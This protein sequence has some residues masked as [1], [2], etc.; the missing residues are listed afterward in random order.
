MSKQLVK[1]FLS[2]SKKERIGIIC[3]VSLILIIITGFYLYPSQPKITN[4][5]NQKINRMID[6]LKEKQEENSDSGHWRNEEDD[7]Q[8]RGKMNYPSAYYAKTERKT[9]AEF[10]EFNPN[11]ATE[12]DWKRLGISGKT[13]RTIQK[14]LAHGGHFYH[15]DDLEK[16]WG[17]PVEDAR[18]L[19]PW[20]R[21]SPAFPQSKNTSWSQQKINFPSTQKKSGPVD[22][23][24][25]DS[26]AF[27]ALP[28]IGHTLAKRIISF[29][30]KLGG[31]YSPNQVAE[32]FGLPD[33]TFQKIRF[34]LSLSNSTVKKININ[35]AGIEEMKTHPYVRY[36]MANAIVQFRNQHGPFH[37]V[38]DLRKIGSVSE[39]ALNKAKPYLV[40]E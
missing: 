38:D 6:R 7:G 17:M 40:A 4:A 19:K 37:T 24:L 34:Q 20:V 18:R 8:E 28:G 13:T 33:S 10:F 27:I 3:L 36:G 30:E 25:A 26:N 21:I 14:Y 35:S 2:F 11:T 15:P 1:E 29:R 5:D 39:E 23:N 32:T 31:F 16:I 22:I 12:N 9:I